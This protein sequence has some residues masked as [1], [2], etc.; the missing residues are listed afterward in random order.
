[1]LRHVVMFKLKQ[2]APADATKSLE[3]GLSLLAQAI[4]EIAAYDYGADLGLREGN[5]DFGLV[6]DF[7]DAEAFHRYS[8]HPDHQRFIRDCLAPIVADRVSVQFEIDEMV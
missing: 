5:F 4:P 3:A 6:A 2:D 1:M 7:V 8:A